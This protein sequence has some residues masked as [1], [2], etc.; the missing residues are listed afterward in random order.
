MASG[1][2]PATASRSGDE[3]KLKITAL[4]ESERV[5]VDSA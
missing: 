4:Q 2:T 3:V 5:L 1:L